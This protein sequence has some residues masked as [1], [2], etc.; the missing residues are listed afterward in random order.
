MDDSLPHLSIHHGPQA[1]D[2]NIR[3]DNP[4][5][6][7]VH[8]SCS[9]RFSTTSSASALPPCTPIP[10]P[11]TLLP[12]SGYMLPEASEPAVADCES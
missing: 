11:E 5:A 3:L 6:E 12:A 1:A 4:V 8:A 10:L 2:K 9:S 7:K